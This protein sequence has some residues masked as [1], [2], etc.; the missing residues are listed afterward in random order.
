MKYLPMLFLATLYLSACSGMSKTDTPALSGASEPS[1]TYIGL[2]VDE[3]QMKAEAEGVPF[4]IVVRD[5]VHLPVTL[6]YRPGRI[7]AEVLQNIV[8]DYEVEG[9]ARPVAYNSNCWK[10]IVPSGCMSFFDG[11]N[12]CMRSA[13]G[14]DPGCTK[15]F[16][17]TYDR[18]R[19]L[20]EK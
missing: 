10:F 16:C 12:T 15:K 5:G 3:A 19:C 6:D 2:S 13:A 8:M 9:E 4:R 7:N 20:D 18:P 11:C 14:E 1:A 17:K